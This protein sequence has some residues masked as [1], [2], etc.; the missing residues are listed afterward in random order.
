MKPQVIAQ[1]TNGQKA[2]FMFRVLYNHTGNSVVDFYCWVSYLLAEA[3]TWS[4]I[5]GGLR[6]FGD[7][8]MLRLLGE[9][10]SFLAAKNRLGDA[11]WRDAF[12]QD[13]D[14]DAEL[15]ASVSRLNATFHEIAPATLKLIGAYIRNNPNDFVQFDG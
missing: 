11:Q 4:G 1:L 15:L 14:D 10:E 13:L 2:Q 6:Y 8:A 3:R 9:T 12:P 7:V 5:Q